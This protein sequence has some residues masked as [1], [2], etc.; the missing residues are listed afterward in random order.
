MHLSTFFLYQHHGLRHSSVSPI[1]SNLQKSGGHQISNM[2]VDDNQ[3][4]K[5]NNNNVSNTSPMV[6]NFIYEST[7]GYFAH[8]NIQLFTGI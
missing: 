4:E 8:N 3:N 7:L 6:R 5:T 2:I 1:R